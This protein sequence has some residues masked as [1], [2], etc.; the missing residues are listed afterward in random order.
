MY[1]VARQQALALRKLSLHLQ[2]L[3][4]TAF[5][6]QKITMRALKNGGVLSIAL[7]S[8]LAMFLYVGTAFALTGAVFTTDS[9]CT[10]VDLNIYDSKADVYLDGGPHHSGSAGLPDGHYFV[11]VTTPSGTQL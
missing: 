4:V 11:Q 10:G 2:Y 1:I 5:F 8:A 9:T 3:F 6:V 7:L